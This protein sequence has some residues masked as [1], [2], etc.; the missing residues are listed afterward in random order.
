MESTSDDCRLCCLV[1]SKLYE[2]LDG[3][4]VMDDMKPKS[5]YKFVRWRFGKE[6]EIPEEWEVLSLTNKDVLI[7]S[8]GESI[9]D[10]KSKGKYPVYGSN[11]IIGYAEEYNEE[12]AILIGRV[13]ASGSIHYINQ[14]VWITDNVLISKMGKKLNKSFCYYILKHLKLERFATKSAQPLLTQSILKVVKISIPSLPEQ[15][16][17]ASI[18]SGVDATIEATR[19]VI[20]KTERLKMGLMQRLLTR[21]INHKKFKKVKWL[22][23][24]TIEIPEE[25]EIKKLEDNSVLKGRI[26][27]QGLTTSEH[28]D[29]GNYYLVTGTDFKS[30]KI[31]W[32]NCVY[33]NKERYLQDPNIQLRE[34]DVLVTKDGT[35]G[36]IAFVS[37]P[38]KPATLNS[39]VFVI[40][41]LDNQYFPLFLYYVLFSDYFEKFL[42]R[43]EA[44]STINHLY[45][46]DFV[47]FRFPIPP[48]SE[49][50]KIASILSGVDAYIQKNQ[51]Y[52]E[53]LERLK[54]GLMQ[55]LL[56]GQI[57]VKS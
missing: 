23:G 46:K 10:I 33:V 36:K 43:L 3:D 12:N 27:W 16:H 57:R 8:N 37:L 29:K 21:G 28:R 42:N 31:D 1:L 30:G 2:L 35:I 51:E 38:R 48:L 26:G 50:T 53:K 20:E 22:F 45:Q 6:I 56:T 11:G 54:K 14:K 32:K 24:K 44:G 17:I 15:T 39:G 47:N 9:H 5:G 34:K 18:L 19:K 25:W 7:L 55:K 49:Q 41:P 52:K 4:I 13:G 40:R